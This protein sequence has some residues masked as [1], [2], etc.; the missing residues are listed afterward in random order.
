LRCGVLRLACII[1]ADFTWRDDRVII[2][3]AAIPSPAPKR[4]KARA[5]HF[6]KRINSIWDA[7]SLLAGIFGFSTRMTPKADI[8]LD[9]APFARDGDGKGSGDSTS[10]PV[11]RFAT[12]S[13]WNGGEHE[14]HARRFP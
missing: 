6:L 4:C 5:K 14:D 7:R 2:F 3:C 10:L 8:D 9:Q 11:Q 12:S 13:S 1:A